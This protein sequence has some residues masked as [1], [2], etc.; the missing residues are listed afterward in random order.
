MP[1]EI[2]TAQLLFIQPHNPCLAIS[3]DKQKFI[4]LTENNC[5]NCN[6]SRAHKKIKP[7][8]EGADTRRRDYNKVRNDYVSLLR[9]NKIKSWKSFAG[10]LKTNP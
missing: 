10:D 2:T 3:L 4:S 8:I 1:I 5:I 6:L 9:K 7:T